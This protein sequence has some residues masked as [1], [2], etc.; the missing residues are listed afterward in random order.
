MILQSETERILEAHL[1][2]LGIG[3]ER[4]GLCLCQAVEETLRSSQI[5]RR[6]A[7]REPNVNT[8]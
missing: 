2:E 8:I 3:V 7:L 1:K 4:A 6:K 5:A